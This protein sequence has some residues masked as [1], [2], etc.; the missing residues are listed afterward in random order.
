MKICAAGVLVCACVVGA[1]DSKPTP[2]PSKSGT[3]QGANT[4][5]APRAAAPD[6][7]GAA[8]P[9]ADGARVEALGVVMTL[10]AGWKS[11]PPSNSMRLAEIHVPDVSGE[12]AKECIIAIS[13]AGGTVEGNIDRWAGQVKAAP[14]ASPPAPAVKLTPDGLP[15][16]IVEFEGEYV[17]MGNGQPQPAWMLRGAI[18]ETA[19]GLLFVKMTG[20]AGPM[21]AAGPGFTE[22]VSGLKKK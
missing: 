13:T 11:T 19:Q 7:G 10:P 16:T 8:K 21:R 15:A 9:G 4:S 17:G 18:V 20:P 12:A 14:G 3:G 2:Q 1:C 22:M 6:H 5:T